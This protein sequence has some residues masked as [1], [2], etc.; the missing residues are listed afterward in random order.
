MDDAPPSQLTDLPRRIS[1]SFDLQGLKQLA[2]DVGIEYENLEGHTRD[3]RALALVQYVRRHGQLASL[4]NAL[5]RSRPNVEWPPLLPATYS[6]A[7]PPYLGLRPF[8][9]GDKERYFGRDDVFARL[10]A[11]LREHSFVALFGSSGSGK[12]SLL[13]A[14]LLPALAS[15]E[16]LSDGTYPPPQSERWDCEVITPSLDPLERLAIVLTPSGGNVADTRRELAD[17]AAVPRL[18]ARRLAHRDRPRLFLLVDQFEELFTLTHDKAARAAFA[19]ALLAAASGG[20]ATILVAFRADFYPRLREIDGLGDALT[21][22]PVD[23]PLMKRPELRLAIEGPA[24]LHG[25]RLE[26]G[27][28][29]TLLRDL[30]GGPG[31]EPVPGAL[32]LLSHVMLET[33]KERGVGGILTHAAYRE[34]GGVLGA[35]GRTAERTYGQ[36]SAVEQTALRRLLTTRLSTCQEGVGF[37]R[38]RATLEEL[39]PADPAQARIVE[40]VIGV[41]AD[42]KLLTTG[43]D[44]AGRE[45]VELAHEVLLTAWK[46]LR[47]WL[48]ED[49]QTAQ[50]VQEV[51]RDANEWNERGRTADELYRGQKL[52]NAQPQAG[53]LGPVE[54]A[55]LAAGQEVERRERAQRRQQRGLMVGAALLLVGLAVGLTVMTR[56]AQSS[57]EPLFSEAGVNSLAAAEEGVYFGTLDGRVGLLNGEGEVQIVGAPGQ[58]GEGSDAPIDFLATD[59]AQPGHVYAAA[60]LAGVYASVD[61]GRT[62]SAPPGAFPAGFVADL[63]A[64]NGHVAAAVLPGEPPFG[65]DLTKALLTSHD[66]GRSWSLADGVCDANGAVPP[67]ASIDT[68][69]YGP[70]GE[71]FV[72][73][74]GGLYQT[75]RD[76]DCWQ[77]TLVAPLGHVIDLALAGDE[78]LLLTRPDSEG[79]RSELFRLPPGQA[80]ER[81]GAWDEGARSIAM[82][83]EGPTASPSFVLLETGHVHEIAGGLQSDRGRGPSYENAILVTAVDETRRQLLLAYDGGVARHRQ[84]FDSGG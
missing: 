15:G 66:G 14:R 10:V 8:T 78:L 63:T 16:R 81:I 13:R 67:P 65:N 38:R 12:S 58:A 35:V 2:H 54:Q 80:L 22:A 20:N 70:G 28:V 18:I 25:L 39:Q 30:S 71:L 57:W 76:A 46:D 60:R 47:Q 37:V 51:I 52:A 62:W 7:E 45:I 50:L 64:Y 49:N 68:V 74:P 5:R 36:L 73:G 24:A 26:E 9:E 6:A 44:E 3:A 17:A 43:Q 29:D 84:L 4:A 34:A 27:F 59:P 19:A 69:L 42:A 79:S 23:L 61:Q 55:F 21:R 1:S 82:M 75:R 32:P 53:Q 77:W 33:W 83:P 31:Q 41:M 56:R 11:R 72:G 48:E 40:R